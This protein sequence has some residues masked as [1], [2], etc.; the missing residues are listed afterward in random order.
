MNR[1]QTALS[2]WR[3][4]R[5][6]GVDPGEAAPVYLVGLQRSGTNMLA[7][8]IE[9][10]PEFEVH[11][12]NDRAAFHRY[13]LRSDGTV[14]GLIARSRHRYVL[15]KPLCDSH[16]ID[17]LLDTLPVSQPGRAVWAYRDVDGRVRSAI[18]KFGDANLQVLSEI[19]RGEGLRRWQ[20]QRIS[21][22]NRELVRSF[23]YSTMSAE[24]AAALFWYIRNC[25][26]FEIGLDNRSDTFLSSYDLLTLEPEQTMQALCAFLGFPYDPALT[27]HIERRSNSR[28]PQLLIDPRVRRSC[29]E[30]TE[31]LDSSARQDVRRWSAA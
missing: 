14:A 12:E 31:R 6:H 5:Q 8:G 4:R 7:R 26:Y 2:K 19:S 29:D 21:S 24:T 9:T 1:A 25:L 18:N 10:A 15:L 20:A 17:E 22:E 27:E 28:K 11:N 3:W 16:R 13:R 23:D 30:L